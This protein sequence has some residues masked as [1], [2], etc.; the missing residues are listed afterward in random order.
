VCVPGDGGEGGAHLGLAA[1]DEEVGVEHALLQLALDG[2]P[3]SLLHD[4]SASKVDT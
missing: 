3:Q 1:V 2:P 4:L